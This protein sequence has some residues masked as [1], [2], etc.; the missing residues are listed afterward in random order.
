[1]RQVGHCR[2]GIENVQRIQSDEQK[3]KQRGGAIASQTKRNAVNKKT[4]S[5]PEDRR[6][7]L[8]RIET[9]PDEDVDNGANE[10]IKG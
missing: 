8:A 6:N 10:L 1:M 5:D 9:I 4:G 2:R 7:N 3:P